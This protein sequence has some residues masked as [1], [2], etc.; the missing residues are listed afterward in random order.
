[1]A[2]TVEPYDI[3]IA[4]YTQGFVLN[5]PDKKWRLMVDNDGV[6]SAMDVSPII[7]L[8]S[9]VG[10]ESWATG[11]QT[12]V[13][14]TSGSLSRVDIVISTDSGDHYN[15]TGANDIA[16][17]GTYEITIPTDAV[18]STC[19]VMVRDH[20][21]LF[22]GS[23]P[24]D[25]EIFEV[26]DGML[27]W[28]KTTE[29]SG[30]VLTDCVSVKNGTIFNAAWTSDGGKDCL[31]YDGDGDYVSLGNNIY[32]TAE[33]SSGTICMWIKP[34][35]FDS[36]NSMIYDFKHCVLAKFRNWAS[37]AFQMEL[38][39][40]TQY[41]YLNELAG[42]TARDNNWHF[43]AFKW[44]NGNFD[45]YLDNVKLLTKTYNQPPP[46]F[47]SGSAD[48]VYGANFTKDG[49]WFNGLMGQIRVF[50]K[51]LSTDEM[52]ALYNAGR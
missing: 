2:Q 18:A 10:G 16:N 35:S 46:A 15:F 12:V 37:T 43:V 28:W 9:P 24:A 31:S 50:G 30:A 45:Y 47:D 48:F 22:Y 41:Q 51:N 5:S 27:S 42:N 4:S 49:D 8:V 13:W 32:S 3:E 39:N 21:S 1:M 52:T 44:G 11:A 29:G 17:A 34:V 7:T 6:I 14:T 19:R 25:L 33:L 20:Y 23:S 26:P 38:Y 36:T 40:P